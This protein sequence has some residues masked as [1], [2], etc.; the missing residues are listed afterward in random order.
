[1]Q[2]CKY[3]NEM[4]SVIIIYDHIHIIFF[5]VLDLIRHTHTYIYIYDIYNSIQIQK[6]AVCVCTSLEA[7]PH[8]KC[9]LHKQ[10][11]YDVCVCVN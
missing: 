1:M 7:T 5:Y 8:I 4:M 11:E 9:C 3:I 6:V 10:Y 2:G